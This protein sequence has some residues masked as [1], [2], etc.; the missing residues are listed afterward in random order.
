MMAKRLSGLA[1]A[2]CCALAALILPGM[3]HAQADMTVTVSGRVTCTRF[4]IP[5]PGPAFHVDRVRLQAQNGEAT[6]AQLSGPMLF[7]SYSATFTSVPS[8]GETVNAYINCGDA[9]QWGAQFSLSGSGGNQTVDS[10]RC[11]LDPSANCPD[12]AF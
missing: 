4:P 5:L 9:Q 7:Q 12:W 2:A 8:G 11:K 1:I 10:S 3:T 6:D